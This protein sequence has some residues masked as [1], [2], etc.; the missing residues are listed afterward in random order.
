MKYRI[1]T[2]IDRFYIQKQTGLFRAWKYLYIDYNGLHI[3]K[4][5]EASSLSF[6][7]QNEAEIYFREKITP[8]VVKYLS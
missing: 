5:E 1:V 4:N 2:I 8:K 7:T 6:G 3:W